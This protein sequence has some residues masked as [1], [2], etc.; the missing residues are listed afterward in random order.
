MLYSF[1]EHF[2]LMRFQYLK[3]I[4][5]F[6]DLG[7]QVVEHGLGHLPFTGKQVV[8]PT[9]NH[10]SLYSLLAFPKPLNFF[11]GAQSDEKGVKQIT[12]LILSKFIRRQPSRSDSECV[13]S[14]G[15]LD[16]KIQDLVIVEELRIK[17]ADKHG[18]VKFGDLK[19]AILYENIVVRC[20]GSTLLW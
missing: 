4:T 2:Y 10:L 16:M 5:T 12:R 11:L 6:A 3:Y 18:I 17:R 9:G 15:M 19:I 14:E 8:T 13:N 1:V 7:H 20:L